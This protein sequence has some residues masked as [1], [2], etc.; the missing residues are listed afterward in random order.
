MKF[1]QREFDIQQN[2]LESICSTHRTKHHANGGRNPSWEETFEVTIKSIYDRVAVIVHDAGS[3][4]TSRDMIGGTEF[5]A[6]TL[7]MDGGVDQWFDLKFGDEFAG[8]IRL[9]SIW[10]PIL[11]EKKEM[12]VPQTIAKG[13]PS[14]D[15]ALVPQGAPV[16]LSD[17][18]LIS[19]TTWNELKHS[20]MADNFMQNS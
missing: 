17:A 19:N 5:S 7:S 3:S 6:R 13:Q 9:K 20:A 1:L 10:R 16:V 8:Q 18:L 14:I 12:L 2:V 4:G 11:E 15:L